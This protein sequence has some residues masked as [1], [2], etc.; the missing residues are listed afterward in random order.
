LQQPARAYVACIFCFLSLSLLA[1]AQVACCFFALISS[2]NCLFYF[3]LA[4]FVSILL[5]DLRAWR[6]MERC[7]SA[8]YIYH[9]ITVSVC[10]SARHGLFV[11]H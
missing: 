3:P 8:S 7:M 4:F 9:C 2:L 11:H 1:A 10:T 6:L 5:V